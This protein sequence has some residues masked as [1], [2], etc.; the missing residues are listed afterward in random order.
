MRSSSFQ[1]GLVAGGAARAESEERSWHGIRLSHGLVPGSLLHQ[2]NASRRRPLMAQLLSE[3]L[4][5]G[6]H[7]H[8]AVFLQIAYQ[9]GQHLSKVGQ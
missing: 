2:V 8:H 3:A 9:V 6:L 5:Y 4:E 1:H 7:N